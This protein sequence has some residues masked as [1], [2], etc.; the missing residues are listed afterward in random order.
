MGT[1]GLI[2]F[3]HKGRRRA[4]YNQ[5][6][7]YPSGLGDAIIKF[8]LSLNDEQLEEMRIKVEH[9]SPSH[10][11]LGRLSRFNPDCLAGMAARG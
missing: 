4:T 1:R 7:S 10:L 6:D 9:V 3:I 11:A 5:W 2:G 8:I